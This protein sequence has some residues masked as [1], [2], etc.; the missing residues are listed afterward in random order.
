MNNRLYFA[1]PVSDYNTPFEIRCLDLLRNDFPGHEI[2][3]PNTPEHHEAYKQRGMPYFYE[4]V[5]TCSTLV[6]VPYRDGEW[7]MGVWCEAEAMANS[8][9]NVFQLHKWRV[10]AIDFRDIRPLSINET[11]RRRTEPDQLTIPE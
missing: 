1:H 3:N 2:V 11:K 6:G 10:M 9:G 8:G 7:G 4:L 5:L